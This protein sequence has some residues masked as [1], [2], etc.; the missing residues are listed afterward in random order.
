MPYYP[1]DAYVDWVA[2][3]I[4][5]YPDSIVGYNN[6]PNPEYFQSMVTSTGYAVSLVNN[7]TYNGDPLR[8]FYQRLVV[9]HG[10]PMMI[11]ETSAPYGLDPPAGFVGTATSAAIK[12]RWYSQIFSQ[13]NTQNNFPRLKAVVQFEEQK[14]EGGNTKDWRV[15]A[16]PT[17]LSTFQRVLNGARSLLSYAPD[18]K[19]D[20]GGNWVRNT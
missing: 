19:I 9:E 13:N 10:K 15:L 11:P 18:F 17:V 2:L 5:W 20:C 3:S 16:D 12:E 8:N 6:L 4:Y 1:G 7:G 14:L